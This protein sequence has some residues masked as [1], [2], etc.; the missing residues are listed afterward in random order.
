VIISA[1][2]LLAAGTTTL[3]AN[4][5]NHSA[6]VTYPRVTWKYLGYATPEDAVETLIWALS[7]HNTQT[8]FGSLSPEC[9]QE[10]R[11]LAAQ[12]KPAVSGE[13]LFMQRTSRHLQG[14][15]EIGVS[16]IEIL[17]TNVVVLDLSAKGGHDAGDVWLKL[18]KIGEEWKLDDLDPQGPNG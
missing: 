13:E 17:V 15:T 8:A 7:Q 14:M 9:Q 1:A 16:K 5:S 18:R 4:S 10:F 12:Q 3:I 11:E 6:P 2:V